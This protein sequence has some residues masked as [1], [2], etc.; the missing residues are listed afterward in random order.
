[1]VAQMPC[2]V[3]INRSND[4]VPHLTRLRRATFPQR[5]GFFK[6]RSSRWKRDP[7]YPIMGYVFINLIPSPVGARHASPLHLFRREDA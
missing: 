6:Y 1:M 2:T 3:I 7:Q 5:E 4:Y